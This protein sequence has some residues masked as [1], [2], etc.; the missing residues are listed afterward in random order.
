VIAAMALAQRQPALDVA[1]MRVA[2]PHGG[3]RVSTIASGVAK[4]GSP[5]L[6]TT[7]VRAPALCGDGSLWM[8]Q[9]A[10]PSR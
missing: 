2:G 9:R 8:A 4:S 5:M 7:I 1:V 10:A 3:N 6:S